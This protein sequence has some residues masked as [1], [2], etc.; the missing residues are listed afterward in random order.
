MSKMIKSYW[1]RH[2]V[3]IA[4][5]GCCAILLGA[6]ALNTT[7][8]AQGQ[9]K[10][11]PS[12]TP[13]PSPSAG[14][15]TTPTL[16]CGAGTQTSIN[17]IVGAPAG[18]T[19]LPAGFSL[20][21]ITADALAKG[22][23][24][25]TGTADDNT[26]PASDSEALCKGSFSGN[27]NLSRYNLAAGESVSVNVGDFLLDQG[28]STNCSGE[29]E[30]G[31]T[32]AFRAFGHAT[33]TLNRSDF[34]ANHFCSTLACGGGDCGDQGC[35]RTQG[36]W[37]THGPEGC[38]TGNNTNVWSVTN[39][40]LGSTNYTD[41]QVCSILNQP[42][43]GNGILALAHQL[44]AAKLNIASGASVP[45]GVASCISAADSLING[46]VIPPVGAGSLDPGA[47]NTL[48]T[49]LREYN[50]GDTGPGHCQDP[51]QE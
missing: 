18:G 23:D 31:T 3:A 35:T 39:L 9:G 12:P 28:A 19:G 11:K 16:E 43:G 6:M 1:K 10:G 4:F 45:N 34:T 21:W 44:I 33:N 20:Q 29:L 37:K 22:P 36:Y 7:S 41:L 27:A 8:S 15:I 26:W 40:S 48:T 24:G 32:Y 17:V 13:T 5:L 42:V 49:C 51:P 14:K 38:A 46:Q 25:I 30:C 2:F 50:E 47:T